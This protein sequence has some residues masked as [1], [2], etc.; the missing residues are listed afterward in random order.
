[1]V[2]VSKKISPFRSDPS[3][4]TELKAYLNYPLNEKPYSTRN[5]GD[6]CINL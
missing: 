2:T 3:E 6:R 5:K 4:L 1:M